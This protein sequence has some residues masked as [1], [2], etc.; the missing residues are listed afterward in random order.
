MGIGKLFRRLGVL[1]LGCFLYGV[2]IEPYQYRVRR[3]RV[4][5]LP[6]GAAPIR[7][8]HISDAHLLARNHSRLNFL[9]A[10]AGL[11][12]DLVVCTGDMISEPEAVDALDVALERLRQFPGVFVFGS[13]DYVKPKPIN[14]L[15]YLFSP[16]ARR[17]F[18]PDLPYEQLAQTLA[19]WHNLNN[20]QVELE[21]R[22]TKLEL[23]GTNDAH[24]DLDDYASLAG[25]PAA[26]ATLIGVTHAPYQ[27]VLDELTSDGARLILTGHTHGG[28]VCVPIY[29][30]LVTNCDLPSEQ[31]KG[32]SR[33]ETG[34]H[35]AYLH[36]SAGV[37]QS[38][39]APFRFSCPPEVTLLT[40]TPRR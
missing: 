34:E 31:A 24:V 2:F 7:V 28:Q 33:W 11:E 16:S 27:R 29:G 1:S 8:L 32:L 13:S 35:T 25:P 39:A 23:R 22:G 3:F 18:E 38:P 17:K 6:A 9:R 26:G 21:L 40:L 10:L 14:P 19:P 4:P 36:V 20:R 5:I 12:P 37:G 30:A 15:K